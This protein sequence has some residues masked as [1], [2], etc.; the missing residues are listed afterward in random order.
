MAHNDAATRT[1]RSM[2]SEIRAERVPKLT[3]AGATENL[4][5]HHKKLTDYLEA[6]PDIPLLRRQAG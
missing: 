3:D 5:T 6:M 1:K 4:A 2:A